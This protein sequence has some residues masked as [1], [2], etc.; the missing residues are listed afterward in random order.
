VYV[1]L[2]DILARRIE[3]GELKPDYPLPSENQLQQ[4]YGVSRNTARHA[5]ALLRERG[6]VYTVT[7]RGTYVGQQE[8]QGR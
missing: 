4:A 5:I 7:G 3:A 8:A 1:Q 2:A 6:L